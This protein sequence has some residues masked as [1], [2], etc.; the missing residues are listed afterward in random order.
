MTKYY[1]KSFFSIILK[2]LTKYP[3][4]QT[5]QNPVNRYNDLQ[6]SS[7]LDGLSETDRK[8]LKTAC[9]DLDRLFW[10][11]RDELS[12]TDILT[13][14]FSEM[15]FSVR[16]ANGIAEIMTDSIANVYPDNIESMS[17]TSDTPSLDLI[18][19]PPEQA[20]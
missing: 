19:S 3:D 16:F 14:V 2:S 8:A 4:E 6:T 13:M 10:N 15:S 1:L 5:F 9:L 18:V 17:Y 12:S 7:A 20:Y 11:G